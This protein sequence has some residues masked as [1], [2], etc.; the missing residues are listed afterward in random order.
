MG[1][2]PLS[3]VGSLI[4]ESA[5]PGLQL[6]RDC[7]KLHF[8]SRTLSAPSLNSTA[9]ITQVCQRVW[10]GRER[11]SRGGEGSV[12]KANRSTQVKAGYGAQGG[13]AM[14]SLHPL[15]KMQPTGE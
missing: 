13:G 6:L 1:V 2:P 9:D 5:E 15:Y 12:Y 8:L 10:R 14:C 11:A 4:F 3:W 7:P